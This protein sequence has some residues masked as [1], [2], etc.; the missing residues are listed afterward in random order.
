MWLIDSKQWNERKYH[1]H[2]LQLPLAVPT[3]DVPFSIADD[4]TFLVVST[5]ACTVFATL[6][7]LT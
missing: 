6:S 7:R 2:K 4:A 5:V 1:K 3:S